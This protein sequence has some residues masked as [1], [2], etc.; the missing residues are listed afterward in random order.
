MYLLQ[1]NIDLQNNLFS[2]FV[3][4]N[5]MVVIFVSIIFLYFLFF[6]QRLIKRIWLINNELKH[7]YTSSIENSLNKNNK[8][9][10]KQWLEYEKTLSMYGDKLKT[11]ESAKSYFNPESLLVAKKLNARLQATVPATLVGLGIL[12]T[13][14][15]LSLGITNIETSSVD[16]LQNSVSTLLSGMAT[17]FY[18]SIAGM[19]LSIVYNFIEKNA[20]NR[21][22]LKLN[23]LID[24]LDSTYKVSRLDEVDYEIRKQH[25]LFDKYFT[26]INDDNLVV[27]AGNMMK[28]I[29][30]ES[31]QQTAALKSFSTDLADKIE[32]GFETILSVQI[33]EKLL[34]AIDNL[35]NELK[36]LSVTLQNPAKEMTEGIIDD[37]KTAIEGMVKEFQKSISETANNE[38]DSMIKMLGEVNTVLN[39]LPAQMDQVLATVEL[40]VDSA[41]KQMESSAESINSSAVNTI[42]KME[43]IIT[44]ASEQFNRDFAQIQETQ[45]QL[46]NQQKDNIESSDRLLDKFRATMSVAADLGKN[47][48]EVLDEFKRIQL[49]ISGSAGSFR[50]LSFT[51]DKST[52]ALSNRL[53]VL[54]KAHSEFD[55]IIK[56]LGDVGSLLNRLPEQMETILASVDLTVDSVSNQL[57]S[58]TEKM[59][60]NTIKS[61][62]K[63]EGVIASANNQFSSNF[64]E[65]QSIQHQLLE[66][67][68]S[69]IASSDKLLDRFNNTLATAEK[70]GIL[71]NEALESFK[72]IQDNIY[73]S[74]QKLKD[75]SDNASHSSE[76]LSERL[77]NLEETSLTIFERNKA[78]I[79][80]YNQVGAE[81][82]ERLNDYV[83]KFNIIEKGLSGV[84]SELN[85]GLEGYSNT[86]EQTT[87]RF[88]EQYTSEANTTLDKLSSVLSGIEELFSELSDQIDRF[89]K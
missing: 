39:K 49:S 68:Q 1:L 15:G 27:Y 85:N 53:E 81:S 59:N 19:L 56:T 58:S 46:L 33:D 74:T 86:V 20:L 38:F 23:K 88:L 67:Q 32:A 10:N 77:T 87:K 79:D 64:S 80:S 30:T 50:E 66:Q 29:L 34:P 41:S 71:V 7:I 83:E 45:E 36:S 3:Y 14:I 37:L 82:S 43:S 16:L 70:A 65:I 5:P 69:N 4:D 63:I 72:A 24:Y 78:I 6:L 12:G 2:D 18:T 54:E 42:E 17:A 52:S 73:G 22:Q 26:V 84:F 61:I 89:K 51:L 40:T 35:K 13:F 55:L 9:L 21:M 60:S 44:N 76:A 11:N 48:T 25:Q 57:K 75:I 8:V 62:E 47:V 31:A 28:D